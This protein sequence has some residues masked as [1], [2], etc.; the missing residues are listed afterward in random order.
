MNPLLFAPA[1]LNLAETTRMVEIAK[2]C[3]DRFPILFLSYGGEFVKLVRDAGF[4]VRPL[5]PQLT[6]E[7]IEHFYRVDRGEASPPFMTDAEIDAR[8]ESEATLFREVRPRCVVTGFC[9]TVPVSTRK[10]GVPLVWVIGASW[11][12]E[13]FRAGLGTWPDMLD[14]PFLRWIPESLLNWLGNKMGEH[15]PR[16][17]LREFHRAARRHGV[18]PFRGTQYWEGDY[19]LLAEPPEFTGLTGLPRRFRHIGPLIARL[20]GEVP[21]EVTRIPRDRPIVWFAMGSS[22]SPE[23]VAQILRGFGQRPYRVIA[24]VKSLI[25][26]FQISVPP[27]VIVTDFLPAHLVNPMADISVIHGGVGTVMTACLSGTP[28]VG[29]GMQPEQEANLECVVRLGFGIRLRKKR[30]TAGGVL[31]AVDRL[32][33]DGGAREKAL[34]FKRILER[35]D[36]PA[37]AARFFEETFA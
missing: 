3:R 32:L 5:H 15:M 9:L 21:E 11:L 13:Y 1:T 28:I 14:F 6:P 23:I 12:S 27:N 8:I 4:E 19:S 36:G 37:N 33:A 18:G 7:R 22:G 30:L 20:D 29:V 24:P 16:F 25:E 17:F 26:R 10:A 2:A 31:D 35:W 34:A